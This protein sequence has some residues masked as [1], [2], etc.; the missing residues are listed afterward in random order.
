[1]PRGSPAR[2]D[3]EARALE[4]GA[5]AGVAPLFLGRV[6]DARIQ[7]G[8]DG[9]PLRIDPVTPEMASRLP[10]RTEHAELAAGLARLSEDTSRPGPSDEILAPIALAVKDGP[11]GS[12][13]R[14]LMTA[15]LRD[16]GRIEV[17][18]LQ[19]GDT[20]P[21]NCLVSG[22]RFVGLVDWELAKTRGA[23][24]FDTLNVALA[25]LEQGVGFV[26][27]SERRALDAFRAAWEEAPL[28][29][30]ARAAADDAARAAGVPEVFFPSLTVGFFGRRLGRRLAF[31][32]RYATGPE[33]AAR[34]LEIVCML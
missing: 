34:M 2:V 21:Q 15:A 16:L 22:G 24:G 26:R 23:P 4:R 17:S 7:E 32:D 9:E 28:F 20:S 11:L 25:C 30:A 8:L 1:M 29:I 31:P 33:T 14:T 13:G 6:G 27:W 10:W 19:H 18:V 5:P 12:R 3:N